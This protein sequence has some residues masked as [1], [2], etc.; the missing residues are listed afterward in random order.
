MVSKL[1][2]LRVNHNAIS[3]VPSLI[4]VSSFT[5]SLYY[6]IYYQI[7]TIRFYVKVFFPEHQSK[8]SLL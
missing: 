8:K 6:L 2:H 3:V 4:Y 1:L 5:I 7:N